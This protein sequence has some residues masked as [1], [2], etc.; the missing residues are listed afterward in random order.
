MTKRCWDAFVGT[1]L[2]QTLRDRGIRTIVLAGISTNIG[3]ESTARTAAALGF[4]V[5]LVEDACSSM[6]EEAHRF[7]ITNIFPRLGH[8][9]TAKPVRL[10]ARV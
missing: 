6:S 4:D 10:R 7:A 2:E 3:V 8:V 9:R 5:V 1:D